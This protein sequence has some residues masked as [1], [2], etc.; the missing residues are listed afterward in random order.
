MN[1]I[2][3]ISIMYN[4]RAEMNIDIILVFNY[5]FNIYVGVEAKH[6]QSLWKLNGG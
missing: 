3:I 4:Y 1:A 5:S 2:S 6:M